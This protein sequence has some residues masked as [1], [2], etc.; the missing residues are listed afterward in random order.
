MSVELKLS[1]FKIA[2]HTFVYS[3]LHYFIYSFHFISFI[4]SFILRGKSID[5]YKAIFIHTGAKKSRSAKQMLLQCI[6]DTPLH[7]QNSILNDA[8]CLWLSR[9][10]TLNCTY[11]CKWEGCNLGF[12]R[13]KLLIELAQP[14]INL[15]K[16]YSPTFLHAL[17]TQLMWHKWID[18]FICEC[19]RGNWAYD[20]Y[21]A[22][23]LKYLRGSI[24]IDS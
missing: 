5:F 7:T 11:V 9:G 12:V 19:Q 15:A 6:L 8:N 3:S 14:N 10:H 21:N 17:L 23:K 2:V 13:F 1:V 22:Y 16:L 24:P 20:L 4:P 18:G